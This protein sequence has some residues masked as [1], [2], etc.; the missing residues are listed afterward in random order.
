MYGFHHNATTRRHNG[1]TRQL[2]T[3]Q[4]TMRSLKSLFHY[5]V[6]AFLLSLSLSGYPQETAANPEDATLDFVLNAYLQATGGQQALN[7]IRTIRATGKLNGAGAPAMPYTIEFQPNENRMRMDF[8]FQ[9]IPGILAFDGQQGWELP[10]LLVAD[11]PVK[12]SERDNQIAREQADFY[13]T[14]ISPQSKD[15]LLELIGTTTRDNTKAWEVRATK[16]D[17][18]TETW[19]LNTQTALPFRVEIK[20]P[21]ANT[22]TPQNS[23]VFYSDYRSVA[24]ADS[25]PATELIWPFSVRTVLGRAGQQTSQIENMQLNV[26]IDSKRFELPEDVKDA[27]E[28]EIPQS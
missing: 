21:G 13:G 7:Q 15:Y 2:S 22:E 17:Q 3:T 11:T 23:V 24:I 5:L 4:N 18:G 28:T 20:S 16:A 25:N 8:V 6:S 14:L 10:P 27:P 26:D 1:H 12:L 19:Y 9:G